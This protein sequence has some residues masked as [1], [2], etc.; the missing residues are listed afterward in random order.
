METDIDFE[1]LGIAEVIKRDAFI[2]PSNQRE[3]A[4][5]KNVQV[6][7]LL[8]DINNAIRNNKETYFLGTVVLTKNDKGSLEIADGQQRLA[9][10]TMILA[11]IRDYF[12]SKG[13]TDMYRSIEN[14]FLFTY[15]RKEKE[16]VSKLTLNLDD[17]D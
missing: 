9:T 7:D 12:L 8:Q 14:D 16:T 1:L 3:Y 5:L 10:T 17:N 6:K 11:A 4:W 15:D 13:D 2:V